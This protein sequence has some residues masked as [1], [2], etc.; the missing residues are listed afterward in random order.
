MAHE[1]AGIK[2]SRNDL[3]RDCLYSPDGFNL[4]RKNLTKS[5]E[6][7]VDQDTL[8]LLQ[9]ETRNK[10]ALDFIMHFTEYKEYDT[11]AGRY[12]SGF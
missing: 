4:P 3:I 6:P 10:K 7:S 8:K 9:D 1:K 2:L 5:K 11:L 12:L